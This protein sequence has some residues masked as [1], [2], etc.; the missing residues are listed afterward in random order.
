MS[1]EDMVRRGDVLKTIETLETARCASCGNPRNNHPFRH[2]FV[3]ESAL[4]MKAAINAIPA[5][6]VIAAQPS[7]DVVEIDLRAVM[8]EEIEDAAAQSPWVPP[9]YSMNEVVSD[10]CAF[11]REPRNQSPDVTALVEALRPFD[12][13]V[14]NDNGDVTVSTGHLK[15]TDWLRLAR[16]LARLKGGAA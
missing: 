15:T 1:D 14:F 4:D 6:Q 16:A 12:C 11:L 5:V 8:M 3:T 7:P 2:Q 13:C 9:E 10:C